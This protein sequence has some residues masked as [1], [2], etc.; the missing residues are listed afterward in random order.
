LGRFIEKAGFKITRNYKYP[1]ANINLLQLGIRFL[2]ASKR[3]MTVIQIGA[4]DGELCDPLRLSLRDPN[5]SILFVEPQKAPFNALIRAYGGRSNSFFENSAISEV[6]GQTEM[7]VP[8][9]GASPQASL[10]RN[11]LLRFGLKPSSANVIKVNSICVSTLLRKHGINAV[12][13][14][15]IDT[16]GWDYR[17]LM[18]F[19]SSGCSPSIIN[20]ETLHLTRVERIDLRLQLRTRGY[21]YQDYGFDTFAIRTDL[22]EEQR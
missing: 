8:E 11:H 3:G 2:A 17:I 7:F 12:D 4:F 10:T 13:V 6:D 14:L 15:Q 9:G 21:Q 1:E 18:Q 16:E 5:I 19:F 20:L 22:L